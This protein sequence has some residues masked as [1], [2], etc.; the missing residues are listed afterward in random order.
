MMGRSSIKKHFDKVAGD[1]D[2]YKKKNSFYY[3][4][5]KRLLAGLIPKGENVLEIGCGTGDLLN[6]LSP[7]K[8]YGYDISSEMIEIAK[9]KYKFQKNL[10]FSTVF[11]SDKFK[12]IFMSDVI[13]HLGNPKET[14]NKV[15][16]LMNRNSK[17]T[18]ETK[19]LITMANPLWEPAL[20]LAEKLKLKMPEGPHRRIRYEDVRILS[21][22]SGLQINKHNY[23][24]LIPIKIPLITDFANKYLEKYLK[25]LCFIEYLIITK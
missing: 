4:S 17:F 22:K 8:G 20:I 23:K 13:E 14:F 7:R 3:G 9:S 6:H 24:L 2:Y 19:F 15:S 21:E 18:T 5:L 11:P 12:Y 1:Y 25:P 10:K 16:K